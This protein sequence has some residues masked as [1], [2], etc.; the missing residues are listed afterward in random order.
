MVSILCGYGVPV[1]S[2]GLVLLRVRPSVSRGIRGGGASLE[3]W[4]GD[5]APQERGR[6]G[7]YSTPF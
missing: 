5:P 2:C 1:W 3:S 7:N 6:R 4:P